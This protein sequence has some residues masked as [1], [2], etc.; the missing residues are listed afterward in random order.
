MGVRQ[1]SLIC[2]QSLHSHVVGC[3]LIERVLA[4]SVQYI[5]TK[6]TTVSWYEIQIVE[7]FHILLQ[8]LIFNLAQI[9]FW[10]KKDK[11]CDTPERLVAY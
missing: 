10:K 5:C 4:V 3:W 6:R 2:S 1:I 7:P 11:R 9:R 8:A